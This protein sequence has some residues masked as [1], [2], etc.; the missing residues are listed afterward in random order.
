MGAWRHVRHRIEGILPDGGT[1]HAVAR[2]AA[3]APATGYY[4]LHVEE[5]RELIERAFVAG[6]PGAAPGVAAT[7]PRKRVAK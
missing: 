7:A 5:E 3:S 1:L 2:K 4:A 6:A